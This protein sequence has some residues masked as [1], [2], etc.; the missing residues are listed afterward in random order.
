MSSANIQ[1]VGTYLREHR[2]RPMRSITPPQSTDREATKK[3]AHTAPMQRK[4]ASQVRRRSVAPAVRPAKRTSVSAT[5][6]RATRTRTNSSKTHT[7]PAATNGAPT[8]HAIQPLPEHRSAKLRTSTTQNILFGALAVALIGLIIR[9]PLGFVQAIIVFSVGYYLSDFIFYMT[10]IM[11]GMFTRADSHIDQDVAHDEWPTYTVLC[12]L[13]KE[14]AVLPQFTAAMAALDYPKDRLQIMLLLEEDDEETILAARAMNLPSYF[15]IIV[16]PDSQP[17]TKP[18]ACNY[19]LTQATGEYSVI[20]D[21]EDIPDPKQLKIAATSQMNAAAAG[22]K[23]GCVQAK[24]NFYNPKHNVL[25]QLFTLEYSLWFEVVLPGLMAIGAPIPLGGTSNHFNTQLLR[26][27]GAWDPYN[28]TEDADLGM[29]LAQLGYTTKI[30]DS[31]TMEEA[32]GSPRSWVKQRSRWIKG[33]MQTHLVHSRNMGAFARNGRF[34][35][36]AYMHVLLGIRS[37][38]LLFSTIMLLLFVGNT[39]MSALGVGGIELSS[40]TSYALLFNFIFINLVYIYTYSLGIAKR[41]QWDLLPALLALPYYWG[42]MLLAAL[43]AAYELIVK[44]YYWQKTEH[45]VHSISPQQLAI[46]EAIS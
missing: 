41:G 28:V 37:F 9:S 25:T 2:V 39:A 31:T 38:G 6:K 24:L 11:K 43:Q 34:R 16:V 26:R 27:I 10:V 12:P 5:K 4:Q 17:K 42:L 3:R 30:I 32:N 18:K 22:Q 20:Y 45:G 35:D 21:A 40:W 1:G 14:T 7:T 23:I 8:T 13:Y 36:I 44:P 46:G 19:G 33:Y 15:D 29:R